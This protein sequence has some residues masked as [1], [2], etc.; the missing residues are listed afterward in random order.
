MPIKKLACLGDFHI[1][2]QSIP[3]TNLAYQFLKDSQPDYI[4]LIG[5]F[6]DAWDLSSFR[7]Y[8]AIDEN[9][10]KNEIDLA[11]GELKKIRSICPKSIIYFIFGN[12]EF[13]IRKYIMEQ[14]PA[15]YWLKNFHLEYLLEF[16]KLN[17]HWQDLPEDKTRYSHNFFKIGHLKIGHGDLIRKEAGYTAKGL[18]DELGGNIITGHTHRLGFSPRSYYDG[19]LVAYENGCLCNLNPDYISNANWQHG[20]SYIE[21]NKDITEFNVYQILIRDNKFYWNNKV[22]AGNK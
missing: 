20:F 13:R 3:A 8:P 9:T 17:I 1:P 5:D 21:A 16:H 7:K 12:H 19:V 2:H 4:F 11:I 6:I 18:R 22:Y 10:F 14:A 15:L